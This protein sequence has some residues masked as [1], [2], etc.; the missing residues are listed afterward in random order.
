MKI[1][2]FTL[3]FS[4]AVFLGV[5][6]AVS[7]LP[8]AMI[9]LPNKGYWLEPERKREM[10]DFLYHYFV[11]FASATIL[12]LCDVMRQAFLVHLGKAEVLPYP[13]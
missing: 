6:F 5:A 10:A 9:N 2:L 4:S 11:W 3:A 8:S 13:S 7:R 12:L 1:Y